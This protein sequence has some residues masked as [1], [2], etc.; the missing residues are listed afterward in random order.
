MLSS[1]TFLVALACAIVLC[2][3][4]CNADSTE[5]A[6]WA[7]F[8]QKY[9]KSYRDANEETYRKNIFLENL[10]KID[11]LNAEDPDVEYAV[12]QFSDLT[13]EQFSNQY[14]MRD[15]DQVEPPAEPHDARRHA[16]NMEKRNAGTPPASFDWRSQK[17]VTKVKDQGACGSCWAFAVAE[18]VESHRFLNNPNRQMMLL[19]PQQ[20]VDCDTGNWGCGGG[21]PGTAYNYIIKAGGLQSNKTYPY[22]SGSNALAGSCKLNKADAAKTKITSWAYVSKTGAIDE[23]KMLQELWEY[24]PMVVCVSAQNWGY[25][26]GGVFSAASGS[27][28]DHCVQLVGYGT[29]SGTPYWTLRNQWGA[30]WGENGYIR[31]KRGVNAC[32][33]ATYAVRAI[34]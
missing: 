32:L 13:H 19:S 22:Y 8:K 30:G 17:A 16:R 21:W 31:V 3:I 20:I 10:A 4:A 15:M 7:S 1:R 18:D 14:L 33:L 26:R 11:A 24:G 5:D 29:A 25:Y 9:N 23:N 27:S 34:V 12:T 6:K 28:L 2:C